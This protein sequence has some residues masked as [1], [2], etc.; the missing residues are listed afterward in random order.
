MSEKPG[1]AVKRGLVP[2]LRFMAF[3]GAGP[4]KA[5]VLGE[6]ATLVTE[7]A[8]KRK[9]LLL[10][11]TAGKG[12]VSQESKFGR[13]IAGGQRKNYYVLRTGEFAYNKSATKEYPEGYIALYGGIELASVPNSIFTCFRVD[14]DHCNRNFL[15]YQFQNNLHGRWLRRLLTVGA[16]AHGSLNVADRDIL[17]VPVPTPSAPST[18]L[19]EQEKIADCLASLDARIA[20]ETRQLDALKAHK[21][22]LSQQLFPRENETAPRSRF[23]DFRE[24]GIWRSHVLGDL[25]NDVIDFRGR[26]PL[27]L[28]MDWGGGDI[29]SLSANNVKNGFID[30]DAECNLASDALYKRWMDKSDLCKGDIVFTMEAPL[31]N[32][33]IVPD[34]KKYVL[35]QRVVAFKT[36]SWVVNAFLL[37]FIWI[38]QFQSSLSRLA[39]GS[40]AKGINQKALKR[41]TVA[42]PSDRDEQQ[43]I[44]DCLTSLDDLLAAQ[45]KKIDLLKQ[46]KRGLMQQLFPSVGGVA[47]AGGRGGRPV[48]DEA[49]A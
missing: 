36:K 4:W 41:V 2:R 7:K 10:S 5:E 38:T 20:A 48:L 39:T 24:A 3:R 15:D 18:R 33:L 21:Q 6:F 25:L 23:P 44:A 34:N 19:A 1:K 31:G 26:T 27:K 37:Q 35:S 8:G 13:E 40:T 45:A 43:K 11:V 16:R 14:K 17:S 28:G 29:I 42:V 49:A 22:G 12:L 47:A 46:H 9:L 30:F 32:A